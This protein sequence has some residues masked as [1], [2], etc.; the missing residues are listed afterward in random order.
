MNLRTVIAAAPVA[1]KVWRW[2][3]APLRLPLA[4]LAAGAAVWYAIRGH[5]GDEPT[6]D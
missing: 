2:T 4:A 6:A 1:K 3:P 5:D